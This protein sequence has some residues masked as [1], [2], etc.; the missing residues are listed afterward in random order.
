M[1]VRLLAA[2]CLSLCCV[3]FCLLV[4]LLALVRFVASFVVCLSVCRSAGPPL[5]IWRACAAVRDRATAGLPVQRQHC[6]PRHVP[7]ASDRR[8]L[9]QHMQL[10][11]VLSLVDRPRPAMCAKSIGAHKLSNFWRRW[12][13]KEE[14]HYHSCCVNEKVGPELRPLEVRIRSGGR[15]RRGAFGSAPVL[16]QIPIGEPTR[17]GTLGNPSGRGKA[18]ITLCF[19]GG[20]GD[21]APDDISCGIH[22]LP[23]QLE[24]E[25][26]PRITNLS[27]DLR[28]NLP[29]PSFVCLTCWQ[30]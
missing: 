22:G 27:Q 7:A 11:R 30:R 24:C 25:G 12:L 17:P 29:G 2:A 23:C 8:G 6:L 3:P 9:H 20:H 15:I 18:C 21:Q 5:L 1:L 13:W 19:A 28:G 10:G 14:H 26:A 16:A 4:R